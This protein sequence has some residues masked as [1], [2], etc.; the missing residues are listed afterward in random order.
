MRRERVKSSVILAVGYDAK[1]KVL[2]VEFHSGRIYH[3]LDV[4]RRDYDA[5]RASDSVGKYFNHVIK[6]KYRGVLQRRH[7]FTEW[8]ARTR[9]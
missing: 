2:E 3:Y 1:R 8:T 6:T 4:S 9:A 7:Q 5:L